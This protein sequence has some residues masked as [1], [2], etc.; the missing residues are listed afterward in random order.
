MGEEVKD[1]LKN[2]EQSDTDEAGVESRL[3]AH[4]ERRVVVRNVPLGT[5]L[6]EKAGLCNCC[7]RIRCVCMCVCSDFASSVSCV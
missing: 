2:A 4:G 5:W 3:A 7:P 6:L 1:L